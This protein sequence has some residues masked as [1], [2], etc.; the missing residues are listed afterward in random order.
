[1]EL[2]IYKRHLLFLSFLLCHSWLIAELPLTFVPHIKKHQDIL[3]YRKIKHN[4]YRVKGNILGNENGNVVI[5]LYSD[6]VCPL[7]YIQNIML[8][9]A[10]KEFPNIRINH[11]NFP[12]DKECNPYIQVNMHPNACFMSKAAI[13]ARNQGNYWEMSSLYTKNSQRK[14]MMF[15]N[16]LKKPV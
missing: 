3:K 10:V 9:Q 8:H 14:W 16:L 5:E 12:F 7:C 6:Y 13:A 4:P 15:L 11:H 1:M 2:K